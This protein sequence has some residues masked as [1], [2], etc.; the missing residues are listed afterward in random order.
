MADEKYGPDY[1]RCE[2]DIM[3]WLVTQVPVPVCQSLMFRIKD[4]DHRGCGPGRDREW[5]IPITLKVEHPMELKY[6]HTLV[7]FEGGELSMSDEGKY[8]VVPMFKDVEVVQ[9]ELAK[10]Q[11]YHRGILSV[12]VPIRF[13]NNAR[14]TSRE[15]VFH[16]L[17][18]G[19]TLCGFPTGAPIEWPE[20]KYCGVHEAADATCPRCIALL[21]EVK[22]DLAIS[23]E[24]RG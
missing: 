18:H 11:C 2:Q 21:P 24:A 3:A 7:R 14:V 22:K 9:Q 17:L 5:E 20:G 23:E 15:T 8:V 6:L 19:R 4:G 10:L 16:I 1:V 13:Q 12:G